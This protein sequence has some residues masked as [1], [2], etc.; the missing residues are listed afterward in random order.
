MS[1]TPSSPAFSIKRGILHAG[2]VVGVA[3]VAL[4]VLAVA[5]GVRDPQKFGRGSAPFVAFSGFVAFAVSWLAQTGR[6]RAALGVALGVLA[7]I[8]VVVVVVTSTGPAAWASD[9]DRAPM[10]ERGEG[11]GA[12]L[13]H[14][15]LGFSLRPLGGDFAV[16]RQVAAMFG[17]DPDRP[18]WGWLDTTHGIAALVTLEPGLGPIA[19]EKRVHDFLSGM[20]AG[21]RLQATRREVTWS[22]P[23]P[24][25]RLE[26]T[27]AGRR[28]LV[29]GHGAELGVK[30]QPACVVIVTVGDDDAA[31]DAWHAS[32][33]R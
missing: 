7:L 26:G 18:S 10:L 21:T 33:S 30:Q 11:E 6:R 25:F 20:V 12:R 1:S 28:I 3:I 13:V 19:P 9:A 4:A 31:L 22:E 8:A 2:V 5:A 17:D 23:D 16:S 29:T 15:T 27:V 24:S 32:F 14:P